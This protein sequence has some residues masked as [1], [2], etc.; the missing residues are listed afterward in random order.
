MVCCAQACLHGQILHIKFLSKR[1]AFSNVFICLLIAHG[2]Q[3]CQQNFQ[4]S[5]ECLKS[6]MLAAPVDV[7]GHVVQIGSAR[8]PACTMDDSVHLQT[9]PTTSTGE[10]SLPSLQAESELPLR[11]PGTDMM[12]IKGSQAATSSVSKLCLPQK[13][14]HRA[15]THVPARYERLGTNSF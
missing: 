6:Q 8:Y 5:N 3:Q 15:N 13:R 7:T 9:W 1:N 12:F 10:H 11:A 4:R 14:C 2:A